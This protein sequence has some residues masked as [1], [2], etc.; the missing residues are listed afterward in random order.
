MYLDILRFGS[1]NGTS[2]SPSFNPW[3]LSFT[4][5][6]PYFRL[7]NLVN[8]SQIF[9][10]SFTRAIFVRHPFDR[11]ASAYKE[12]IATLKQDRVQPEPEYDAMRETICSRR[13]R[14]REFRRPLQKGDACNGTI[15]SFEEF[16]RYILLDTHTP[17]GIARMNYHWQPYSALCQVCKFK[18]NFVGKYEMFNDHFTSFLKFFNLSDWNIQ[19]R[20]GASGLTAQDYQKFYLTL[21]DELLCQ[22]I[23][24]Y[25]EDFRIFNY[26]IDD[27]INRTI[28]IQNCNRLR[29]F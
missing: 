10:P 20:N 8:L 4:F 23:R 7:H 15:P 21:P 24:I 16:I 28:A 22:L 6:F 12:R 19:K 17:A 1:I 13:M 11:L 3:R 9:S 29:T 5:S 25:E 18:Y 14:P 26:R 27:Y 2:S